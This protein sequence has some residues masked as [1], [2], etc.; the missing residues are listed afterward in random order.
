MATAKPNNQT[1]KRDPQVPSQHSIT[2]ARAQNL[3]RW[4][5]KPNTNPMNAPPMAK[6]VWSPKVS[7]KLVKFTKFPK[8]RDSQAF[9]CLFF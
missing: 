8:G 2:A 4:A 9:N 6:T 5:K 1:P 3:E 7:I